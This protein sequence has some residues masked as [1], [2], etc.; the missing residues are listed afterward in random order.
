MK[1]TIIAAAIATVVAAPAMADVSVSGQ[2]KVK[3][4]DTEGASGDWNHTT[5]NKLFFKMSED[6]GNGM[7]V[8]AELGYDAD[9]N[10]SAVALGD[11]I[12]NRFDSKIA[13]KGGFGTVVVGRMEYLFESVV[14][15]KMDTVGIES[16]ELTGASGRT[17]AIGYVSPTVN[18]VHV[19]AAGNQDSTGSGMFQNKEFLV[20]YANGPISAIASY[21][22]VR[23]T[24]DHTTLYLAY[25]AGDIKVAAMTTE[26]DLDSG[27]ASVTENMVRLDYKMGNNTLTLG[28]RSSDTADKDATGYKLSHSMSKRT[29]VY[30]EFVDK[31]AANS[32]TTTLGMT[33][34]F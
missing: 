9:F 1:K 11:V 4:I 18:G 30:A 23:D 19:A 20:A 27:A 24:Q 13:L 16:V 22:D 15:N 3:L 12:D 14:S 8:A 5:D 33:H 29:S 21:A 34:K 2:V 28:N 25:N 32:D 26:K 17:N 6:L 31:E 7:T 10:N